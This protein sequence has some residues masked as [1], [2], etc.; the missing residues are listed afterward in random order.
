MTNVVRFPQ[1]IRT[2]FGIVECPTI[3]LADYHDRNT[4]RVILDVT[5]IVQLISASKPEQRLAAIEALTFLADA[6]ARFEAWTEHPALPFPQPRKITRR[7]VPA[8]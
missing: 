2:T 7:P 6:G 3:T 4:C 8:R 1:R 5:H